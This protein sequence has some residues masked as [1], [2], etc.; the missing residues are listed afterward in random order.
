M[1][2]AIFH[3]ES[4]WQRPRS[5]YSFNAKAS[6]VPQQRPRDF[7]DYCVSKGWAEEVPSPTKAE[8]E[9]MRPK[10]SRK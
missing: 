8:A 10:R 6:P 1:A 7:V 4:N 2:W 9:A 5:R 3:R